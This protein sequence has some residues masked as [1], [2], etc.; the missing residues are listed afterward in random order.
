MHSEVEKAYLAG[1]IDGEGS[2]G[3]DAHGGLRVPSVRVTITNSCI[4][5]ADVHQGTSQQIFYLHLVQRFY[6]VLHL[7]SL[8]D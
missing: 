8:Y 1:L 5:K 2:I 3:I 7:S 6:L 4:E